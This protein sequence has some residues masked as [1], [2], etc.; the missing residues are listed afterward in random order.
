MIES[1]SRGDR[2]ITASVHQDI[3]QSTSQKSSAI[4]SLWSTVVL[5]N[6]EAEQ[7]GIQTTNIT[8]YNHMHA[9]TI[10]Y[11]EVLQ[12]YRTEMSLV[13][14][15]PVLF[16]PFRPLAFDWEQIERLWFYLKDAAAETLP[17]DVITLAFTK[18]PAL[19]LPDLPEAPFN[20]DVV[21]VSRIEIRTRTTGGLNLISVKLGLKNG[22]TYVIPHIENHQDNGLTP[23]ERVDHFILSGSAITADQLE[24]V[25]K[26]SFI[27]VEKS[28]GTASTIDV[29]VQ[30]MLKQDGSEE[31]SGW[32]PLGSTTLD[33]SLAGNSYHDF[34]WTIA[35][36]LQDAWEAYQAAL[37]EHSQLEEE[38]QANVDEIERARET[39]TRHIRWKRYYFT[40]AVLSQVEPELLTNIFDDLQISVDGLTVWLHAVAH[41]IPV[42][43]TGNAF[44][45]KMKQLTAEQATEAVSN[46][47]AGSASAQAKLLSLINYPQEVHDWFEKQ[48]S[49]YTIPD[50]IYLPTSGVFAEAILG[51]ANAA[52]KLDMTRHVNW[53]ET[54]IPHAAP[55]I[56][57][58]DPNV[59]R[60]KDQ[61]VGVTLPP[62][63][64]NLVNPVA[65]PD[66]TGL[67]GVLQ[68]IQNP[69]IFRDMSKSD[70]LTATLSGL[71][72]LASEMGKAS[73]QMTGEAASQTLQAATQIGQAT[74]QL[75]QSLSESANR[76]AANPPSTMTEKGAT[77]NELQ[78]LLKDIPDQE[79]GDLDQAKLD[80]LGVGKNGQ[81]TPGSDEGGN[82]ANNDP[83]PQKKP[84]PNPLPSPEDRKDRPRQYDRT[85]HPDFE[86]AREEARQNIF[87]T[88]D[89]P[90]TVELRNGFLDG[91]FLLSDFNV[92]RANIRPD[93]QGALAQIA[94]LLSSSEQAMIYLEGHASRTGPEDNNIKLSEERVIAA[95]DWLRMGYDV[96]EEKIVQVLGVGSAF[97]PGSLQ[98]GIQH[99]PNRSVVV[100]YT[101]PVADAE[102][103][104]PPIPLPDVASSE[105]RVR[106]WAGL[107][108]GT[109]FAGIGGTVAIIAL[110]DGVD[111]QNHLFVYAGV[112]LRKI[113]LGEPDSAEEASEFSLSDLTLLG[114]M[115]SLKAV[116]ELI[117]DNLW[118]NVTV[119]G[120]EFVLQT[121]R[122]TPIGLNEFN[123]T[124][125]NLLLKREGSSYSELAEI[126]ITFPALGNASATVGSFNFGATG[127]NSPESI[128][129]VYP[130]PDHIKARIPDSVKEILN[131]SD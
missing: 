74:A 1:D 6:L 42:G 37:E 129:N 128:G 127:K 20:P 112:T 93:H 104:I 31:A 57:P 22:S 126:K 10:Q 38:H 116:W 25:G 99:P 24:Q 40:Q 30:I 105:W 81:G 33:L 102:P 21:Q 32:K 76:L 47:G 12:H 39:L 53:H 66:P 26:Y 68:A 80:A 96:P 56:L 103:D 119:S 124:A 84:L 130:M 70:Q 109:D 8:N 5:E 79:L 11:Y 51:R 85:L 58:V 3:T 49:S 114:G 83:A 86:A 115:T 122:S 54:P 107:S 19:D 89:F 95:Y 18:L 55:Q 100:Y 88:G 106:V 82:G 7:Q 118:S 44:V 98:E 87:G 72:T 14:A 94:H 73:S 65:F 13:R 41:T 125:C 62:S 71:A 78:K 91:A 101:I 9:L 43:M 120:Q 97:P 29:D 16:L 63:T 64:I 113:L 77:L 45:L 46:T 110:R 69:N 50:D 67:N 36:Q 35:G 59:D 60:H 121:T 52:E 15:E 27:R 23:T 34:E 111:G 2:N 123:R 4:R 90:S 92:N 131:L 75:A 108:A 61:E 17:E 28:A 48:A 117:W